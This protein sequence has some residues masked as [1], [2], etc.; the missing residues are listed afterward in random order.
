LE[1]ASFPRPADLS[2]KAAVPLS[3]EPGPRPH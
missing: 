2:L 3:A 1:I